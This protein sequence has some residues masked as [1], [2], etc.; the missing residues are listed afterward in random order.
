MTI[1]EKDCEFFPQSSCT[2]YLAFCKGLPLDQEPNLCHNDTLESTSV[3][4]TDGIDGYSLGEE[5]DNPFVE[6]ELHCKKV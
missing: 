3:C 1:P 5:N 2:L 6:G 4:V